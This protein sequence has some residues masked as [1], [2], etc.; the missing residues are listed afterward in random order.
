MIEVNNLTR[1]KVSEAFLKKVAEMV[2]K[3]ELALRKLKGK[4]K[5]TILSVALVSQKKAAELNKKY[6]KKD[7]VANVLSFP[8][9]NDKILSGVEGGLGEIVLCPS[10]IKKEAKKYGMIFE[11]ALAWMFV[12]GILHLLGYDHIKAGGAKRM[13]QKERMYLSRI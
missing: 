7:K 1:S 10:Q 9:G 11:Q 5:D 8:V 2:L 4:Q 6:R 3:G 13:E 12:H